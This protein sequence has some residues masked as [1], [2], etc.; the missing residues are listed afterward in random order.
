MKLDI[1]MV[2]EISQTPKEND[3]MFLLMCENDT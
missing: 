1:I 2:G 3:Y